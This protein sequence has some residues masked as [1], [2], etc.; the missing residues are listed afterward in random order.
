LPFALPRLVVS[1][2]RSSLGYEYASDAG[3]DGADY[4]IASN[5]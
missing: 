1:A 2:V 5:Y 3:C 4:T